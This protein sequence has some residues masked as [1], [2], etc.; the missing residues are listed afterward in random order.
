MQKTIIGEAIMGKL[1][2]FNKKV[3]YD[4]VEVEITC[5]VEEKDFLSRCFYLD[6]RSIDE[7][8]S[9][10][11]KIQVTQEVWESVVSR[12]DKMV[13]NLPVEEI[14]DILLLDKKIYTLKEDQKATVHTIKRSISKLVTC[15]SKKAA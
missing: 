1:L 10:S 13:I 6:V 4:P 11:Q 12:S 5:S 7:N 8:R 15:D 9:I 2:S 3:K 14:K